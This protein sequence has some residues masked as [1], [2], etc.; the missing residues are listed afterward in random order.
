MY[1]QTGF[2]K[3]GLLNYQQPSCCQPYG[4]NP[5][6]RCLEN[7]WFVLSVFQLK[8]GHTRI[9][10]L[11][12]NISGHCKSYKI[13]EISNR[14]GLL[15]LIHGWCLFFRT[16]VKTVLSHILFRLHYDLVIS[17]SIPFLPMLMNVHK[18]INSLSLYI[19]NVRI[20]IS[21]NSDSAFS[22]HAAILNQL[23][24]SL[25]EWKE[26]GWHYMVN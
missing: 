23:E 9:F 3:P 15:S 19:C 1:C 4:N 21:R 6:Q 2:L 22:F 25:V 5:S 12:G 11:P 14:P 13:C 10:Q 16:H 17:I 7:G 24:N 18:P 26:A 8:T 20:G